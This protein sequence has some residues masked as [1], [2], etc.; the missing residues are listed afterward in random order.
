MNVA[1]CGNYH[2]TNPEKIQQWLND[3]LP[4]LIENGAENFYLT[5]Y[6]DFDY[7]AAAAVLLQKSAYKHINSILVPVCLHTPYKRELYDRIFNPFWQGEAKRISIR[8][9]LIDKSQVVIAEMIQ[10]EACL[11]RALRYAQKRRRLILQYPFY[12]VG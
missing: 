6:G 12:S 7:L 2:L 3:I 1:F 8:K 9:L 4:A 11:R 10:D 5:N